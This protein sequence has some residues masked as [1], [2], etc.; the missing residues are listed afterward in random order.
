MA[1]SVL[2]GRVVGPAEPSWLPEDTQ[3]ILGLLRE[4]ASLCTGCGLPRE[5]TMGH[6]ATARYRARVFRC[7][8]CAAKAAEAERFAEAKG[9]LGGAY[10]AVE[11]AEEDVPEPIVLP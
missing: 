5:E 6:E 10:F 2:L 11:R 3:A 4:R 1:R 7:H 8:A 9:K